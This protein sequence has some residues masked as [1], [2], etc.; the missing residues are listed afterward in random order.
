[1]QT[2][3]QEDV[4]SLSE[5]K[6]QSGEDNAARMGRTEYQTR[7]ILIGKECQRLASMWEKI[8]GWERTI[9]EH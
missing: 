9:Q 3:T 4:P 5:L 7:E 1:M 8:Q 2:R 6:R